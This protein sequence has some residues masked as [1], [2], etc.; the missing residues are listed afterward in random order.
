V[1]LQGEMVLGLSLL[2]VYWAFGGAWGLMASVPSIDGQPLFETGFWDTPAVAIALFIA[3]VICLGMSNYRLSFIPT[4]IYR[5]G[6]WGIAFVF[7][8]RAIGK[9]HYLGFFKQVNDSLF[10]HWDTILYTPL[11]LGLAIF[12]IV[13]AVNAPS[14]WTL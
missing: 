13:L 9:F 11:C 7:L 5:M 8:L 2:H 1:Q 10:A 3:V 6:I 4:W 12:C 14:R